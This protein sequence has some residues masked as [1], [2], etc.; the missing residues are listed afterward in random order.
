MDDTTDNA[1]DG[2]DTCPQCGARNTI[3]AIGARIDH[4][5]RLRP[6]LRTITHLYMC[7]QCGTILEVQETRKRRPMR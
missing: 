6:W 1:G 7:T 4:P 5:H 2:T 3:M